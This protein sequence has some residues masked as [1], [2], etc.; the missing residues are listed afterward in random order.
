MK[1]VTGLV[2][3]LIL[4]FS[5]AG[6]GTQDKMSAEAQTKPLAAKETAEK[7]MGE[8]SIMA[9][10]WYQTSGE[11]K[12]LYYQG[13][14]IGKMKLDEALKKGTK[15]KPA[16]VLD[17]DETVLDNSPWDAY[18]AQKGKAFPYKWN[19]WVNAAK[20]KAVPGA[21]DF[22]NDA[23]KKGVDIYYVSDR[24]VD[25]LDATIKNLKREH[26]PQANKEHVLLKGKNDTSKKGRDDRIAKTHDIVLFFGD[27]LSDFP[28]FKGKSL[29][30]RNK[31]V[32]EQKSQFGDKFIIMPNPMYGDWEGALYNFKDKK[33]HEKI[34]ERKAHL[35]AFQ[36]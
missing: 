25:Q 7:T 12:A 30:D 36:P 31:A 22:L 13:Y 16:V 4:S 5:L 17:L 24:S 34:K 18:V 1:K 27:N 23:N 6:C 20:A 3:A 29:E 32:E 9:D 33:A 35:N 10:A 14:N 19:E 21:V 8:E 28:N 11:A 26:I 2:S 15:K